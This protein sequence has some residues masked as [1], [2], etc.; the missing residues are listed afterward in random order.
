MVELAIPYN[1]KRSLLKWNIISHK[2]LYSILIKC[3][4]KY[5]NIQYIRPS[6]VEKISAQGSLLLTQAASFPVMAPFH[7]K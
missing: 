7:L 3:K 5:L 1:C 2:N 4:Q 6:L